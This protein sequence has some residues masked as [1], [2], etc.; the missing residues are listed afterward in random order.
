MN[1]RLLCQTVALAVLACLGIAFSLPPPLRAQAQES[2]RLSVMSFNLR[3]GTANDGENRWEL[4]REL[5]FDVI[6][7]GSPDVLGTQEA[8]R[9]Q[10]DELGAAFPEYAEIGVGRDDD[11][12]GQGHSSLLGTRLSG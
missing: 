9:F 4:S 3:Y 1:R 7:E 6:R 5:V 12:R 10:L 11:G 2:P 8:L